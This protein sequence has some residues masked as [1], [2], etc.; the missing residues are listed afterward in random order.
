MTTH[1]SALRPR[2][3]LAQGESLAVFK[4]HTYRTTSQDAS[5]GA[6]AEAAAFKK[7][8]G[9]RKAIA[10]LVQEVIIE[11]VLPINAHVVTG[12]GHI[13]EA[14][15]N[16]L[17]GSKFVHPKIFRVLINIAAKK[18]VMFAKL[19]VDTPGSLVVVVGRRDG[20]PCGSEFNWLPQHIHGGGCAKRELAGGNGRRANG[21]QRADRRIIWESLLQLHDSVRSGGKKGRRR[22]G[23][24]AGARM[25]EIAGAEK[26]QFVL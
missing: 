12:A 8:G 14:S 25:L 16:H 11:R 17:V 7:T 20:A 6:A 21:C 23:R 19:I 13:D 2:G 5:A 4:V 24:R 22:R 26:P 15:R 9:S 3:I 18:T 1:N 10:R